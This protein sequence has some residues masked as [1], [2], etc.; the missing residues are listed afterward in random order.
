MNT[1]IKKKKSSRNR[2]L[3]HTYLNKK[4]ILIFNNITHIM[5][6]GT[7]LDMLFM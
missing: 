4:S 5:L 1:S 3:I 7:M 6:F 2:Y